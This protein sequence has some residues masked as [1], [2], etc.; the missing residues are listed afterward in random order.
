MES[1]TKLKRAL[2]RLSKWNAPKQLKK[3]MVTYAE[4][5]D[6]IIRKVRMEHQDL[7]AALESKETELI[8]LKRTLEFYRLIIRPKEDCQDIHIGYPLQPT[9]EEGTTRQGIILRT[10]TRHAII[11]YYM[12][13]IFRTNSSATL[14]SFS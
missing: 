14:G 4:R 7:E 12:L 13:W 3:R 6:D 9:S 8:K 1:L 5:C 2:D 11:I 10:S